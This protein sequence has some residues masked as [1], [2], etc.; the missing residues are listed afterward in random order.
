MTFVTVPNA[1]SALRILLVP[2]FLWLWLGAERVAEAG[3]M[4]GVIGATDWIDGYLARRLDQVSTVGE[5]LDPMADRLAVA[6]ALIGGLI[7]DDI[8]RWFA[9]A[10]LAREVFIA[11]GALY[12]AAKS[13]AKLTVRRI[14]K[15]ATAAVYAALAWFLIGRGSGTEWVEAAAWIVGLPGLVLYYLSAGL[16]FGDMRRMLGNR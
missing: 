16:Y 15:L 12:L 14:G 1:I 10:I 3:W 4:L 5:F 6:S 2:L 11:V 8:P 9:A 7:T 13:R